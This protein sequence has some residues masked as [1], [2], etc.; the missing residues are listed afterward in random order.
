MKKRFRK[1]TDPQ[2]YDWNFLDVLIGVILTHHFGI[3]NAL[4][5]FSFFYLIVKFIEKEVY[6]EEIR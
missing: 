1:V 4:M 2:P 3:I 6:F 5:L